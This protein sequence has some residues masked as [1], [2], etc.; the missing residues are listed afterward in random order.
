MDGFLNQDYDARDIQTTLVELTAV[1]IASAIS[2]LPVL[3]ANCFVCGGGAHNHYLLERLQYQLPR[4]VVQTTEALGM[5][6]DYIEAAAFAWLARRTLRGEPGN[7]PS[8]TGAS[9]EVVLGTIHSA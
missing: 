1:T 8:V 9:R 2:E 4:C 3:P 5:N 7:L 6:P